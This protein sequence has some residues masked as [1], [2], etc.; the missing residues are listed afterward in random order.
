MDGIAFGDLL[1]Y[2]HQQYGLAQQ[3]IEGTLSELAQIL[4]YERIDETTTIKY[5]DIRILMEEVGAYPATRKEFSHWFRAEQ[6][7]AESV[8]R[9]D[10][11]DDVAEFYGLQRNLAVMDMAK[12]RGAKV[13]IAEKKSGLKQ[14]TL[15]NGAVLYFKS[16][17]GKVRWS[18]LSS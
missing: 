14:L 8:P 12:K 15:A 7:G 9:K 3:V 1:Y 16:I 5:S 11:I 4:G 6:L 17:K 18:S 2:L 13:Q 10:D